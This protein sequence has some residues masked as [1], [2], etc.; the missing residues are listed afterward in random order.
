MKIVSCLIIQRAKLLQLAM[1]E[2]VLAAFG[3]VWQRLPWSAASYH[4]AMLHWQANN[5]AVKTSDNQ[6][7]LENATQ[8]YRHHVF[9]LKIENKIKK[10]KGIWVLTLT[11]DSKYF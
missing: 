7:S 10:I 1:K 9:L 2:N 11:L 6:T 4:D 5:Q 3:L 8:A